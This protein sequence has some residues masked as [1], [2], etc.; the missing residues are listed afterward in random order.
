MGRHVCCT[1][2]W[3]NIRTSRARTRIELP[4]EEQIPGVDSELQ[5]GSFMRGESI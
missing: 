1:H 3:G 5:V 2:A 4:K